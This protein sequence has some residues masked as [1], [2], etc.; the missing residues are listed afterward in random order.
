M[1]REKTTTDSLANS[2]P[3]KREDVYRAIDSE[4]DYQDSMWSDTASD[5]EPGEGERSRDE[6][7]LYIAAYTAD[8]VQ[9]CKNFNETEK[10]EIMRKIA[11]LCVACMEQH[12]VNN[13]ELS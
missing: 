7:A 8:L 11:G 10:T 9:T 6:F 1:T 12:G 2:K 5:G 4:R 3:M 13:R